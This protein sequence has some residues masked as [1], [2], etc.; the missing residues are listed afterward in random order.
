MK[1]NIEAVQYRTHLKALNEIAAL[2]KGGTIIGEEEA[3]QPPLL[4]NFN[5]F[6]LQRQ[7]ITLLD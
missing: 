1:S 2:E 5:N 7:K 6:R 4:L 3:G